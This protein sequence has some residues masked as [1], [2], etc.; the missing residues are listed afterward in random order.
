[1]KRRKA[2]YY[3]S[4]EKFPKKKKMYRRNKRKRNITDCQ[5]YFC[6]EK[7]HLANQCPKKFNKKR[8]EVD[9]DI[10]DLINNNE[11]IKINRFAEIKEISSNESMFIFTD[12]E[13]EIS[14]EDE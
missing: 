2:K 9:D 13:Y 6:K 14:S 7:G 8:F 1:M 4:R 11:L 12:T 10:E 3:K 5:C